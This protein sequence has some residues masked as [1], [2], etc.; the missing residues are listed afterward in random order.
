MIGDEYDVYVPFLRG[1][2]HFGPSFYCL[3]VL[4]I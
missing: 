3:I 4:V 1:G 2:G